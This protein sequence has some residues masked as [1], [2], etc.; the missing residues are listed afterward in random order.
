[1]LYKWIAIKLFI[2]TVLCLSFGITNKMTFPVEM[3]IV[4]RQ[5]AVCIHL[6]IVNSFKKKVFNVC[7]T[8]AVFGCLLWAQNAYGYF[9]YSY[10]CYCHFFLHWKSSL[11][12]LFFCSPFFY[13]L[14]LFFSFISNYCICFI[15]F[16][17]C[18]SCSSTDSSYK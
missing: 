18:S 15:S 2:L 5:H 12:L 11:L 16:S 8:V 3:F 13:T 17:I 4:L 9:F 6:H 1:M 7:D 10:V 14:F